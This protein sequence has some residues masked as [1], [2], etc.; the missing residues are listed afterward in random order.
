[1]LPCNSVPCYPTRLRSGPALQPLSARLR[2]CRTSRCPPELHAPRPGRVRRA[3]PKMPAFHLMSC[4]LDSVSDSRAPGACRRTWLAC[5]RSCSQYMVFHMSVVDTHSAI[6]L[7]KCL[8]NI[9]CQS[10]LSAVIM[11]CSTLQ[12]QSL[13][14]ALILFRLKA[15]TVDGYDAVE[16]S[17]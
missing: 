16:D 6:H 17:Q 5:I 15:Y 9:L 13:P 1:M 10:V 8:L 3:C 14:F 11:L 2:A 4:L 12:H 7:Q